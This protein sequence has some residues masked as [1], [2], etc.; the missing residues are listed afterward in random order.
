MSQ[1]NSPY[2][3][4]Y[5]IKTLRTIHLLFV[6]FLTCFLGYIYFSNDVW[7]ISFENKGLIIGITLLVALSIAV[8][9]LIQKRKLNAAIAFNS[10]KTVFENYQKSF[11]TRLAILE[12]TTLL[13]CIIAKTTGNAY[14][15]I[16]ALTLL[17]YFIGLRPSKSKVKSQLKLNSTTKNKLSEQ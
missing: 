10:L 11:I 16:L 3:F 8:S 6:L 15:V 7:T 12:A 13:C 4:N 2:N 9:T 17:I 14:Y 1:S 5:F